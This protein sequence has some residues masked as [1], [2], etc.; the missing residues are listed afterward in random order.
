MTKAPT[1]K[2]LAAR[3]LFAERSRAGLLPRGTGPRR[4]KAYMPAQFGETYVADLV[5][6]HS[7]HNA[8]LS[9]VS[10][11]RYTPFPVARRAKTRGTTRKRGATTTTKKKSRLY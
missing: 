8:H 2:Q 4:R 7:S 1:A 5:P 10:G 6:G 11:G 9:Q 3:Q